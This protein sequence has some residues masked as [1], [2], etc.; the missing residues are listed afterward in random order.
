MR[1]QKRDRPLSTQ[2]WFFSLTPICVAIAAHVNTVRY[3]FI[4][5]HFLYLMTLFSPSHEVIA[6]IYY[7]Y[8]PIIF[9]IYSSM[10][11][12]ECVHYGIETYGYHELSAS[13]NL[14][15]TTLYFGCR[16]Q[17]NHLNCVEHVRQISFIAY[18]IIFKVRYPRCQQRLV[19][20]VHAWIDWT[21]TGKFV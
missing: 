1:K 13:I 8:Y 18:H 6:C 20:S 3:I 10:W 11:I 15:N 21:S 12:D 4:T 17:H 16:I 7:K 14:C 2:C 19:L 9:L 5:D